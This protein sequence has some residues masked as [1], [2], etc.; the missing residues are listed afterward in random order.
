MD[1][2]LYIRP[3]ELEC[4][5]LVK[6]SIKQL[7]KEKKTYCFKKEQLER[8]INIAKE[9]YNVDVEIQQK[10]WFYVIKMI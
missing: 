6:D 10:D 3:S 7:L 4:Y 8:I 1:Y 5:D 2:R 9:K